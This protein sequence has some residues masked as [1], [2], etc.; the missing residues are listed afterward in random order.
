MNIS[1]LRY[2]IRISKDRKEGIKKDSLKC[3]A[4]LEQIPKIIEDLE[5]QKEKAEEYLNSNSMEKPRFFHYKIPDNIKLVDFNYIREEYE[6]IGDS[7]R[8]YKYETNTFIK[9]VESFIR[10]LKKEEERW[11]E[12]EIMFNEEVD[13]YSIKSQELQLQLDE[14]IYGEGIKK[15]NAHLKQKEYLEFD[16]QMF[17]KYSFKLDEDNDK[18]EI[19]RVKTYLDEKVIKLSSKEIDK[20]G[21][22]IAV[23]LNYREYTIREGIYKEGKHV[24]EKEFKENLCLYINA[25]KKTKDFYKEVPTGVGRT[26]FIYKEIPI[27]VKVDSNKTVAKIVDDYLGQII[28]YSSTFSKRLGILCVLDLSSKKNWGFLFDEYVKIVSS[29][30]S[31]PTEKTIFICVITIPG[32]LTSPSAYSNKKKNL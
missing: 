4:L 3:R 9:L 21:D 20:F 23:I 17:N 5:L 6:F 15:L 10:Y 2:A 1:D 12:L 13:F 25:N 18:E 28:T 7:Q 22:A 24:S 26:D 32:N 8:H 31:E 14:L 30:N 29:P 27:E 11:S 19:K 16:K